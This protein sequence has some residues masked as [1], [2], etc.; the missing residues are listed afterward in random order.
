MFA[1]DMLP[2]NEGDALWVEYGSEDGPV[3]RILID[4]GRKT[5]YRAVA[6]RLGDQP[7]LDFELFVLTHVDADHIA[8]A[9]PLLQDGRF[10]PGRVRDVWF[11]GWCHLNR[12]QS[13]EAGPDVLGARQGEYFA[14]VLIDKKYP[15]NRAFE[16]QAAVVEDQGEL[17]RIELPDGMI[18]TLLSPTWDKLDDMRERWQ[19]D[20]GDV[21]P[22]QRIDPGDWERALEVLGTHRSQAPEVLGGGHEGPIIIGELGGVEFDPDGSEPN[23]S[24]IAFLAEHQGKAVLFAGDTHAPQLAASVRRLNAARGT[25]R[26][27]LDALKMSH[28]GSARNNSYE[29]LEL[30]DCK[31][32]LLSTNGSRHHHPDPEALA[33]VLNMNPEG[34]ELVFNYRSDESLPWADEDLKSRHGY[35]T[36]YPTDDEDAGVHIKL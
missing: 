28:H 2:A 21:R 17:P 32:Y 23:G 3:R 12:Q 6:K 34:V 14:A 18:L 9:V 15:W 22:E 26:L 4:C 1:I 5:A 25:D 20:L 33:R 30:L 7:D 16:G 11:N 24:S 10:G 27:R 13:I 29:I 35:T 19:R 8:G 36:V 31:R